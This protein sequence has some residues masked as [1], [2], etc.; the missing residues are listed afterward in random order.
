ML[1][2]FYATEMSF[3]ENK[4]R[5]VKS[6]KLESLPCSPLYNKGLTCFVSFLLLY[7]SSLF[8]VFLKNMFV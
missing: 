3:N 2:C 5:K 6:F 8:F 1:R 7:K 4:Y